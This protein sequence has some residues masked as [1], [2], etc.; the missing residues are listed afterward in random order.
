MN[1]A[2]IFPS[3][4]FQSLLYHFRMNP[5][6]LLAKTDDVCIILVFRAYNV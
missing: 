6:D 5:L 3:P 2:P 4:Q 1:E